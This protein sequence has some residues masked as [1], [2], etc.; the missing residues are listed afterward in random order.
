MTNKYK[1]PNTNGLSARNLNIAI[2]GGGLVGSLLAL[3]LGKKGHEVDLYEYRE[4]IRTA[5]LVIGRSINLALSARGRKALAEVGLEQALLNHGIPMKG[6]ML[7]DTK[8]NRKIVPYDANNNQCIYSVGRKHLNEVLLD[9]AEK[10]PNI[11]LHFHSKLQSADLDEG[12]LNFVNPETKEN[13]QAI[14]DLIVGCDGA[15]SAVRK[16]IIKRPGYDFSQT[17]IEHG[18]LEL[19]IPSTSDGGFAMPENYLHIWPR[20]KFMMIALPNQDRTWTVTLFMPFSNFNSIKCDNELMRFFKQ[21]FPDAIALIGRERLI[22]DFFK[23][24]PQSLVMIKCKPYN[25][26]GK[27]LIIGDAAHAMVPFYGQGMNAGFED[28]TVLSELF[29]KHGS[30]I[31]SVLEE[32]SETRWEDAHSICDLAMYNYIE[33][34]DLVTKR[35]YLFRKKLDE[36]LFWLLPNTWLP[37]YNSVSFSHMRYSKCIANRKWQDQILTRVLYCS[38]MATLAGIGF[39]V[40]RHGSMNLLQKLPLPNFSSLKFN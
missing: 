11:R 38:S 27:A 14:A 37:L 13:S 15:F 23:T 10:Y 34:R 33:M 16:E 18:Y 32:F 1:Q 25:V 12:N 26:A 7:H 30:D 35:T 20:G 29:N 39:T 4:D 36:I 2:V 5:E 22:K 24:K 3:H 8:G 21:Y 19:C 17:Y 9:A 28:C 31:E 40:Y 6:R